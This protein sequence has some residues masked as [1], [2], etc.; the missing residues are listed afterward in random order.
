MAGLAFLPACDRIRS[1]EDALPQS[2][3]IL[4]SIDTL[5]ADRLPI[6]GSARVSTPN[7]DRLAADGIVYQNAYAHVPLTLPSHATMM[8]G[9]YPYT[10]GVRSNIGYQLAPES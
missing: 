1:R 8:T 7:I 10:T 6:Y 2:P 4:I 3:V 5:R 9:G